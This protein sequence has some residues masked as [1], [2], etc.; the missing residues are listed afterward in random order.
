MIN[1][2]A[3][4]VMILI[5]SLFF[6]LGSLGLMRLPDIYNRLQAGTKATTM[7]IMFSVL[8]IGVYYPEFILKALL[9]VT[10]IMITNPVSSGTLARSAFRN[11]V[12]FDERTINEVKDL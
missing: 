8:G 11:R 5:G 12:K 6:L 4:S 7:G 2:I 1:Q 10:F 3:G 9:I